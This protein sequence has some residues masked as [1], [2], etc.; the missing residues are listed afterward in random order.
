[1]IGALLSQQIE[2]VGWTAGTWSWAIDVRV[3][4]LTTVLRGYF[5]A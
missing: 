4:Q 1:V 3:W 5:P 2:S